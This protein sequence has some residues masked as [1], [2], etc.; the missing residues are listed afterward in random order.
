MSYWQ[1]RPG[2]GGVPGMTTSPDPYRGVRFPPEVIEHAVWLYHRFSLSLR[3][4]ELT[5]AAR[6]VVVSYKSICDQG[7]RFGRLFADTLK[8]RRPKPGDKWRLDQVFLHTQGKTHYLWRAVDQHGHV[9]DIL[10]QSRRSEGRQAVLAQAAQGPAIRAP[11]DRDRQA[12]KLCC[13]KA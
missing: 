10:V 1:T 12:Q 6:G 8:R 11:C 9:L 5:L 7:L 3:D 13:R 4:V 2:H